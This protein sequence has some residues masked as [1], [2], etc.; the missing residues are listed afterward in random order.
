[1]IT[2]ST[3]TY[4]S[5][6][7]SKYQGNPLIEAL[8]AALT[9]EDLMQ[10]TTTLPQCPKNLAELSRLERKML[11]ED[12]GLAFVTPQQSI[13]L[14]EEIYLSLCEGYLARNPLGETFKHSLYR[15]RDPFGPPLPGSKTGSTSL[16]LIGPT[17]F[18]KTAIA[19]S[20]FSQFPTVI[21]HH[22]YGDRPLKLKQV[23]YLKIDCPSNGSSRALINNIWRAFDNALGTNYCEQYRKSGMKVPDLQVQIAIACASHAVGIL[24]VDEVHYLRPVL[25]DNDK[26]RATL[27]F[28]D[29]LL[30]GIGVPV[31]LIGTWKSAR[32]LNRSATTTRRVCSGLTLA[33]YAYRANDRYW[34][35]LVDTLWEYQCCLKPAPLNDSLHADIH[36]YSGGLPALLTKLLKAGQKRAI[37]TGHETV[38]AS[39]LNQVY[40]HEFVLLHDAL[41]ALRRGDCARFED[42]LPRQPLSEI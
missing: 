10:R 21:E 38:D 42:L 31:L 25:E 12:I 41:S 19:R 1:M 4:R 32:L 22:Q 29:E 40:Q 36:R 34:R 20:V 11:A 13:R 26:E 16:L 24:V 8:P 2:P 14:Y 6:S 37:D 17:G 27:P 3:A 35:K 15:I 9:V 33:E 18:G 5:I 23:V 39:I 7:I 28:V 30:N